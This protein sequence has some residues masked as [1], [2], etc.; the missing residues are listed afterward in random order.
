V[1]SIGVIAVHLDVSGFDEKVGR[2]YTAV[3]A[4]ARKN[5]F[6]SHE[7]LSDQARA[8]LQAEIDR[9][10]EMFVSAVAVHRDLRPNMVRNTEAALFW[11][12][13]GVQVGLADAVGGVQDCLD[14]LRAGISS[15]AQVRGAV[16]AATQIPDVEV[17]MVKTNET[18]AGA[19][20]P[21]T[22]PAQEPAQAAAPA[23]E[24]A[25][26]AQ[27]PAPELAAQPAQEPAPAAQ[28][29][30]VDP[31]AMRAQVEQELRAELEEITALCTLA[32]KP[33]Y[34]AEAISKKMSAAQVREAL[35]AA[36]AQETER[37]A[38][39]STV[40]ASPTDAES[41]LTQQAQSLAASRNIPFAQA[42]VEC[43]KLNPALYQQYLA[44]KTAVRPN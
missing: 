28:P 17:S 30:S 40:D 34:V 23:P 1:G 39:G 37:T 12:A 5:D 2:K 20:Q 6:S 19:P 29:A 3:Y 7:P 38:V 42:Y 14:A 41:A 16:L 15:R 35:L 21:Q 44:E 43:L 18:A 13:N 9:L 24:T 36:R 10:Y 31:A 32:G 11:G 26:A 27:E 25:P 22:Q 4:G 33:G 8:S